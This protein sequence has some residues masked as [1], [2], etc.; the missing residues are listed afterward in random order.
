MYYKLTLAVPKYEGKEFPLSTFY[1][2]TQDQIV[3]AADSILKIVQYGAIKIYQ[4]Q[5]EKGDP[6]LFLTVSRDVPPWANI[7]KK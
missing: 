7:R 4:R 6:N 3:D 5:G 1:Q 2:A